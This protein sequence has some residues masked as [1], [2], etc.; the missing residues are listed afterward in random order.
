MQVPNHIESRIQDYIDGLCNDTEA[1]EVERNIAENPEWEAA[2][3]ALSEVHGLLQSGFEPLEP[4]MRF[5]KNVM[6]QIAGLKIAPP[7]RKY[8]NPVIVWLIGGVLAIMLLGIVGYSLSLA[9]WSPG[10]ANVPV[11]MPELK[12]P[13]VDW[14]GY[15]NQNTTLL[16][17]LLNTVLGLALFDKWLR[18][19]KASAGLP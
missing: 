12:M 19:K 8:L 5:S 3:A 7:T 15:V 17:L 10:T 4:S 6:E 16:F 1:A 18:R 2:F 9:D 14:G 11:K 13:A